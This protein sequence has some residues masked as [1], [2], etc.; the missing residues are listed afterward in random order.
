MSR[1]LDRVPAYV[2]EFE[3][4]VPSRPD[5]VLMRQYGVTGLHRL[6]NNEN[7]LGPPPLAQEAIAAF[8]PHRAAIYPPG[9]AYDL[10]AALAAKFGKSPDQF[11]VGN[12]SCEVISSVV[13]AFCQPGDAVV[14][15]DKTFAV[16]EWVARFSGVEPVLVPLRDQAIDAGGM[17]AA[18]TA[19]TKVVFI[20]NPNNPTGTWWNRQTLETFLAGLAGRAV[21][22]L[23]EAYREY[24]T[25]PDFPDG[26]EVLTRHPHVLVFR[27]FSKMYGLA[28]L[29][30]GYLC[31]SQEAVDIVRRTHI[32][33]SVNALGQIAATAALAD[34][35]GH[36]AATRGMVAQARS[37]LRDLFDGLGLE[38]VAGEGN[39]LMAR[40]PVS[41]T[42][43]YRRLMREGVMIRTMTGF[44]F[45]N[46]IR[47]SLV[48][49]PAMAAF[50]AA[51]KK[52][53][54]KP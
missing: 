9:D 44:R 25:D 17:L 34:D 4:Y 16:Y 10:R 50:A 51:L 20:C 6:N 40:T 15:A 29:R 21:V 19:R 37:F 43:L 48:E 23:D 11:L 32:A 36:I 52:V 22:V 26:L 54:D 18:V 49:E 53:L 35:A 38:Y 47:V 30:V 39:F 3:S 31:G 33:Y 12:G 5:P 27:T 8:D 2:R 46:W 24:V 7:A 14:T 45:P 42:L 28:G 13:R 41:D 1:L